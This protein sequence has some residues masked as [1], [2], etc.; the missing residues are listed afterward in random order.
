MRGEIT[1]NPKVR[2]PYTNEV[3]GIGQ[4][5]LREAISY[6]AQDTNAKMADCGSSAIGS[7][8]RREQFTKSI[9]EIFAECFAIIQTKNADYTKLQEDNPYHN[10]EQEELKLFLRKNKVPLDDVTISLLIRINEK[11][12]RIFNLIFTGPALTLN[13]SIEDTLKD[14][15]NLSI[16]LLSHLR[17]H[18]PPAIKKSTPEEIERH[19][20]MHIADLKSRLDLKDSELK[21]LYEFKS[22]TLEEKAKRKR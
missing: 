15:A 22:K 21:S 19:Y 17:S 16:I 9:Q 8:W 7:S 10:F 1:Y 6:E 18:A 5:N 2:K 3:T 14:L 13:E 4:D 20:T 12:K 11:K